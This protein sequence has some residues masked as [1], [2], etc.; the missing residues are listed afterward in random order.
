MWPG[1]W[2]RRVGPVALPD[3]PSQTGRP[4][5]SWLFLQ[6]NNSRRI[7]CHIR[8][9]RTSTASVIPSL[10]IAAK[11]QAG[12]SKAE[13]V[14]CSTSFI[15]SRSGSVLPKGR[16]TAVGPANTDNSAIIRHAHGDNSRTNWRLPTVADIC[17]IINKF[18]YE[19]GNASERQP[20]LC[21]KNPTLPW[22]TWKFVSR[23]I[24]KHALPRSPPASDER[25]I[26]M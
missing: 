21:C 23:P 1:S 14:T 10:G 16:R 3:C 6:P 5:R 22:I 24:R 4:F 26:T 19:Q 8:N 25:R 12:P 17:Q 18:P 20:R 11:R 2:N 15:R 13:T 7:N 9:T